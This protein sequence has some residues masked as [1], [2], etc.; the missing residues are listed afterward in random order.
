MRTTELRRCVKARMNFFG[1]FL[2]PQKSDI[3]SIEATPHVY[4]L[5]TGDMTMPPLN[6]LVPFCRS[7]AANIPLLTELKDFSY[8]FMLSCSVELVRP[9]GKSDV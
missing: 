5:F 9:A 2:T 7:G 6:E 8:D 4:S 1:V 3:Y